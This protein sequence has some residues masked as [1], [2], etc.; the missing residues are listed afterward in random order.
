MTFQRSTI[1]VL[2]LSVAAL[3]FHCGNLAGGGGTEWEAKITGRAAYAGNG[4]PIAGARVVLCPER[5]LKDTS[6]APNGSGEQALRETVTD[7]AGF[8]SIGHLKPGIFHIEVNDNQ[9]WASLSACEIFE[10]DS[11]LAITCTLKPTGRICGTL[12][13]PEGYQ[14]SA[15]VQVYGLD[16]V[17][18]AAPDGAFALSDIPEGSFTLRVLPSVAEYMPKDV[19]PVAVT[20]G[21]ETDLGALTVPINGSVWSYQRP[22][23]LNTTPAGADVAG[24]VRNFPVRVRLTGGNFRFDQARRN[25]EDLRFTKSDDTPLPFEIEQWDPVTELAEVW[26]RV[27][28]I[29]GNNS[30]QFIIMR[31][32][33]PADVEISSLS[34]GMAVFDTAAGFAGVWHLG[35]PAGVMVP[36]ATANGINGTA[37]A[38]TT[39]GGAVGM[40]QMFDGK[41]TLIQASGPASDNVNFPDTGTYSV[42]AWVK[43]SVLD[44]LC[45]AIVFKSNAQYGM[46]IIP[47]KEWE[48]NTYIEKTRWEGTRSPA[49]AGSWHAI[50]GVRNGTRQYLYVD[51]VCVDSSITNTITV[52]PENGPRAYDKPLE[53]GHCPDG[54]RNP[55]RFFNGIIDEVRISR[56]AINADWIKLCYMNQ[57]EQDALVKW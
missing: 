2:A 3:L 23:Y 16:R 4:L 24:T 44:S 56:I 21:A 35:Q 6:G 42:S 36:D 13:L 30:T 29:Y 8:F 32:G 39:V 25:G 34:N 31:W 22:L 26:V 20:T 12:A 49:S 46:Q 37:T 10:N 55:D 50:A 45:Q 19:V 38:T 1:A 27:D 40:A 15:Y 11:T 54:G 18:R 5:Y 43:A 28:M 48:F 52:A 51:G 57:K 53:I 47:E 9:S 14:G 17:A 7:E 41:T 33:V